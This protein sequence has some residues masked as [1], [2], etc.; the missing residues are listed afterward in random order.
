MRSLYL[1]PPLPNWVSAA[2][3]GG[4]CKR[5]SLMTTPVSLLKW[6]GWSS[7]GG[8]MKCNDSQ[9]N[10]EWVLSPLQPSRWAIELSG[11]ASLAKANLYS[12]TNVCDGCFICPALALIRCETSITFFECYQEVDPPEEKA[13]E[14]AYPFVYGIEFCFVFYYSNFITQKYFQRPYCY[15]QA[16]DTSINISLV[17]VV[18]HQRK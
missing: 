16:N 2:S 17:S 13:T 14:F 5:S 6:R 1:P 10:S 12:H 4:T 9:Q 15:L 8:V 7:P 3:F 11:V 18:L